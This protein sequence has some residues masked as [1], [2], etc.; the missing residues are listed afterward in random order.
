MA[1]GGPAE[2]Q[3][4][5]DTAADLVVQAAITRA[6][7]GQGRQGQARQAQADHAAAQQ[8]PGRQ[9]RK[10]SLPLAASN[11]WRSTPSS[12]PPMKL[13]Q[14]LQPAAMINPR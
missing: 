4:V 2:A 6:R 11:N 14:T 12:S 7:R 3:V 9:A 10:I 13:L 5:A 1:R 8:H